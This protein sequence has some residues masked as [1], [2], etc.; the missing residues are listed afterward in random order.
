MSLELALLLLP[1][2]VIGLS[3]HEFAHAWTASLLGDEFARR[4]KRVSLNPFRHLSPLG[5]LA[6]F[7][8]GFGWGKPVPVNLYNFKRPKRDYLISSLAGPAA[9]VIVIAACMLLMLITRRTY[10]FG[11]DAGV[12]ISGGH[13]LLALI[14]I[15]NTVLATINLLPV[16]PLDGS[17]IWPCL[18]PRLRPSFRPRTTLLFVIILLGLMWTGSLTPLIRGVIRRIEAIMPTSDAKLYRQKVAAGKQEFQEGRFREAERDFLRAVK[19][20]PYGHEAFY[21]LAGV[22]HELGRSRQ[23]LA[24][25]NRAIELDERNASYYVRRM[26]IFT[27][28]GRHEEALRDR[29]KARELG[30]DVPPATQPATTQPRSQPAGAAN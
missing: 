27:A 1:G 28:L 15:I 12:Y 26:I 21:R 30:V 3:L 24:D 18:I 20:N 11:P 25:I 17:K 13:T 2:L 7:W 14:A 6:L 4:Q 9:N 10:R 16:P 8:L 19:I 23:A 5:T 29:R 22:R